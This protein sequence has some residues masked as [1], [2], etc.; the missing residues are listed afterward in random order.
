MLV[1][2]VGI[3]ATSLAVIGRVAYFNMRLFDQE[4]QLIS[5]AWIEMHPLVFISLKVTIFMASIHMTFFLITT[6]LSWKEMGVCKCL[7]YFIP[8]YV[9]GSIVAACLFLRG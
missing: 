8:I 5:E 4:T 2:A 9:T 6:F 1:M 7:L 3:T